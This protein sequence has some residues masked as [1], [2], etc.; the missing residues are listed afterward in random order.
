M[1]DLVPINE[2]TLN[3]ILSK[4]FTD[5]FI[6]ITADKA[7]ITDKKIREERFKK[8]KNKVVNA[9]YSYIPVWG[10]YTETNPCTG[11]KYDAPSFEMSLLIPN[12]KPFTDKSNDSDN[13]IELGK[14]LSKDDE[15]VDNN[16]ESFLYK[17]MGNDT[18]SYWIDINGN[19]TNTFN[20]LTTNDATQAFFTK[21]YH[22]KNPN[23]V[24]RRFTMLPEIY[25]HKSPKNASE[26]YS[27]FGEQFFKI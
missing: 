9:G 23:K 19:I 4:H 22:S 2:T 24:D 10:G 6:I 25:L 14:H 20:T 5:G 16:Q 27:R 11:E 12:Q 8:L 1:Q 3:R 17:P 15:N 18:K 21:I 26:A 7:H 13:L